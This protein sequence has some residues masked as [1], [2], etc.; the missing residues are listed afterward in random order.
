MVWLHK[1]EQ[2][3]LGKQSKGSDW[4][5]R[6]SKP[7]QTLKFHLP[8]L[9]TTRTSEGTSIVATLVLREWGH[10]FRW[11][12][13]RT[14]YLSLSQRK[15]IPTL[16]KHTLKLSASI[17]A[18]SKPPPTTF[19]AFTLTSCRKNPKERSEQ[20]LPAFPI[21]ISHSGLKRSAVSIHSNHLDLTEPPA[22]WSRHSRWMLWSIWQQW[23]TRQI[24]ENTSYR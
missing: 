3:S 16:V 5:R 10:A 4:T 1:C 14:N 6:P 15:P 11:F 2:C 13:W 7:F 19:G 24:P 22:K 12:V 23:L 8:T 9:E 18:G 21:G 20:E 17:T